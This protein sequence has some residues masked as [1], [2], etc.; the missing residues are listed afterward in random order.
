MGGRECDGWAAES[1]PGKEH[2]NMKSEFWGTQPCRLVV[3]EVL[4]QI[5]LPPLTQDIPQHESY[6]NI[7]QLLVFKLLF[8]A[9]LSQG[10]QI[11][12]ITDDKGRFLV[13]MN[14]ETSSPG[15][16]DSYVNTIAAKD[17]RGPSQNIATAVEE[18]V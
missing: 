15:M 10:T 3:E 16:D 1:Q 14:M 8:R 17:Y 11:S 7:A 9:K 12:T 18:G 5:L 4:I 6:S 13:W 2:V